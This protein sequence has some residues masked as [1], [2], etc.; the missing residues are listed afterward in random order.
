[1]SENL[2][3]K[4][5]LSDRV[6]PDVEAAPWV[7]DEIRKLELENA[8]LRRELAELQAPPEATGCPVC[9]GSGV[10]D[11][12]YMCHC[13]ASAPVEPQGTL[14][15]HPHE[16]LINRLRQTAEAYPEDIFT[17]LTDEDRKAHGTLISRASAGMGRHFSKLFTAAADALEGTQ[18]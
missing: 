14:D 15:D 6:R 8:A 10:I 18:T 17:P 12:V 4:K 7:V 11:G 9:R 2:T 13:T 5:K 1:M 16:E 3:T